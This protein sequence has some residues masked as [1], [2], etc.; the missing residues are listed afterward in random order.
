MMDRTF[1]IEEANELLPALRAELSALQEVVKRINRQSE[2]LRAKKEKLKQAAP[3]APGGTMD[4]LFFMEEGQIDFLRMQ[5][6]LHISNFTRQGVQ[7]KM[8]EP[9]LLDFPSV[10]NGEQVLICWKEGEEHVSH[11]HGLQDG[12]A[13]RK[14]YPGFE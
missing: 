10:L 3:S 5:A 2:Q 6:E 8:I 9:G 11:Y 14:P 4:E 12:F 1:T 13:G 7:L